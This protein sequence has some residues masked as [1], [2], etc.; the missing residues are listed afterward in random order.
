MAAM[1]TLCGVGWI[2]YRKFK[3]SSENAI[4]ADNHRGRA[5]ENAVYNQTTEL[6]SFRPRELQSGRGEYDSLSVTTDVPLSLPA[7]SPAYAGRARALPPPPES[8]ASNL[9]LLALNTNEEI[10]PGEL[11]DFRLLREW[12]DSGPRYTRRHTK[13]KESETTE[14]TYL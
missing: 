11:E 3:R 2:F 12:R 9:Q 13:Q 1:L 7:I 10:T 14:I 6:V 8:A 5:N 4:G